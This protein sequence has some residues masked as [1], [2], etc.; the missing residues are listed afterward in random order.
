MARVST[1]TD[2]LAKYLQ[3]EADIL[4][5][6]EVRFADRMLRLEDLAEIRAGRKEWERRVAGES[7]AAAGV[8]TIGGLT[9]SRA[10]FDGR[11]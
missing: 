1:A 11:P 6:K 10:R 7:N 4:A 5:G 2:M 8:P 9:F 3:A